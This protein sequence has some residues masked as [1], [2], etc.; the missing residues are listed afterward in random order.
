MKKKL[1]CVCITFMMCISCA[2]NIKKEVGSLNLQYQ[3]NEPQ[4]EKVGLSIALVSPQISGEATKSE[5][6][7]TERLMQM[8]AASSGQMADI[9]FNS[10]FYANRDY[11]VTV[12][13][14]FE[15]SFKEILTKK[16]FSITGPYATFDDM[17]YNEKKKGYLA[18]I[19]ILDVE[20]YKKVTDSSGCETLSPVCTES[21]QVQVGGELTLE[22]IE[23]MTKEKIMAKRVNLSEFGIEIP[24]RKDVQRTQ[25]ANKQILSSLLSSGKQFQDTTD[26]ALTEAL[27]AFYEKSLE[28]VTKFISTE[29]IVNYRVQIQ[30]L[31][32]LKRF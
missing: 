19:P 8:A 5:P 21:G 16:G 23:P 17:T 3:Y 26:K 15:N 32:G 10:R 7:E 9:D 14:S 20:I 4:G 12:R 6:T 11:V 24:Y 13:K 29:E 22:F 25:S 31:K 30:E 1:V 18:L 2:P 27:N 28:K